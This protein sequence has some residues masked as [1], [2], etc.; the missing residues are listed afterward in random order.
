MADKPICAGRPVARRHRGALRRSDPVAE[1]SRSAQIDLCTR[2]TFRLFNETA[3][4][5]S[6]HADRWARI[7]RKFAGYVANHLGGHDYAKILVGTAYCRG[8]RSGYKSTGI[9]S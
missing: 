6:H 2:A 3:V 4:L 5:C 9:S 1:I 8:S 7:G